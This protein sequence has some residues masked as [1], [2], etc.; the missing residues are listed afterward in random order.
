[1]IERVVERAENA[2]SLS[3]HSRTNNNGVARGLTEVSWL[4]RKVKNY[5]PIIRSASRSIYAVT[6]Y[7]VSSGRGIKDLNN[8]S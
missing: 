5:Y 2:E 8:L 4:P 3:R 1:L 6:S 7:S